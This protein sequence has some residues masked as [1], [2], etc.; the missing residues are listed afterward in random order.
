M[1]KFLPI[2]YNECIGSVGQ[3]A[4]YC[5][6]ERLEIDFESEFTKVRENLVLFLT[7]SATETVTLPFASNSIP[8]EQAGRLSTYVCTALKDI[9]NCYITELTDDFKFLY[10]FGFNGPWPSLLLAFIQLAI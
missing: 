8:A 5:H 7:C 2:G 3:F 9:Y 6:S 1:A 10:C 4:Q